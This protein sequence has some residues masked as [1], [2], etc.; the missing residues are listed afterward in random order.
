MKIYYFFIFGCLI[1]LF[2]SCVSTA[3]IYSLCEKDDRGDY[4]VKWEIS[5]DPQNGQVEIYSSSDD[6]LIK[7]DK[8]P[9]LV[10]N[11]ENRVATLPNPQN[12]VREFFQLKTNNSYSGIVTN[13]A[14]NFEVIQNFRDLGGYF[15][16]EGKQL[17]WNK[18]FRSGNMFAVTKKDIKTLKDLGIK[19]VIDLRNEKESHAFPDG[20]LGFSHFQIPIDTLNTF[21]VQKRIATG[22]F[23]KGDALIYMQ[24]T[25][26]YIL[27]NKTKEL[28]EIFDILLNEKNYPILL[29]DNLGKDRTGIVSYLILKLLNVSDDDAMDDY[30]LSN[31]Y[32]DLDEYSKVMREMPESVQEAMTVIV[33]ADKDYMD[34]GLNEIIKEY[35]SLDIYFNKALGLNAE[36]IKKLRKIML[37]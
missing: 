3:S 22:T 35:G 17:R 9:Q 13:R 31:N 10:T 2:D 16:D 28:K 26:L 15:N 33:R 25:Y 6:N 1:L 14:I 21:E 32:I 29:H 36:K 34:Y 19:T 18:L 4:V 27:K 30:L 7:I 37:Y 11:V 5:P 12:S 20:F 23:L 8:K 24:D